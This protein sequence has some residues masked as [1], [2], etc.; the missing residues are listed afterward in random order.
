MLVTE[1]RWPALAGRLL[2]RLGLVLAAGAG[3]PAAAFAVVP[4]VLAGVGAEGFVEGL[5]I[6]GLRAAE[7]VLE[8]LGV[9]FPAHAE[10]GVVV[11]VAAEELIAVGDVSTGV[12]DVLVP[13][14]I[15]GVGRDHALAVTLH[16]GEPA[17]VFELGLVGLLERPALAFVLVA[18]LHLDHLE[19]EGGDL[20][21]DALGDEPADALLAERGGE[22]HVGRRRVEGGGVGQEGFGRGDLGLGIHGVWCFGCADLA[23]GVGFPAACAAESV[24]RGGDP[25][26][27]EQAVLVAAESGAPV[28]HP[29]IIDEQGFARVEPDRE[30]GARFERAEELPERGRGLS[31]RHPRREVDPVGAITVLT[32]YR[33]GARVVGE[34]DMGADRQG[35]EFGA[36]GLRQRVQGR[37]RVLQQAVATFGGLTDAFPADPARPGMIR[38]QRHLLVRR[39]GGLGV[40]T[41]R[42]LRR[43]DDRPQMCQFGQQGVAGLGLEDG[44]ALGQQGA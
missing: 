4:A 35:S 16:E 11:K 26:T 32:K 34:Y 40:G 13:E 36:F 23:D 8:V 2:R 29:S 28:E 17:F 18:Q 15:D 5:L 22:D 10:V 43:L 14:E 1:G 39:Q 6:E 41:W 7:G 44:P 37:L 27:D 20:R 33:I 24:E 21:V 9:L 12:E 30:G 25:A 3:V 31:V 42:N 38:M 19:V